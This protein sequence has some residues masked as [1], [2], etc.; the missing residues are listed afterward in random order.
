MQASQSETEIKSRR[1]KR[2][3]IWWI[4]GAITVL[5]FIIMPRETSTIK[6]TLTVTNSAF[7]GSVYQVKEWLSK[8]ANDPEI[9]YQ[10]WGQVQKSDT[11]YGVWAKF[12]A[13]NGF[14]AYVLETYNFRLDLS[15][16]VLTAE[17][18]Q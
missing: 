4:V 10:S 16:N 14:G 5:I 1:R 9:K 2:R 12:R 6:E 3:N 15:G 13:K 8:H 17:R 7:D 11:G 18:I